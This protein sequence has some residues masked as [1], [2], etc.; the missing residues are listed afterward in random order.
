VSTAAAVRLAGAVHHAK[1]AALT[2]W[3]P[4]LVPLLTGM[5]R[6][7]GHCVQSY[8]LSY[9][10]VPGILVPAL[11]HL[12]D[13]AFVVV[14]GLTTVLLFAGLW[15]ALCRLSAP[16]NRALQAVVVLAIA[17]ESIG[18]AHALRA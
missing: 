5:L 17:V 4:V 6:D 10:L 18:Y 13:A 7:C 16:W 14:G 9:V 15:R 12:D 3:L 8:L 2:L 11:L 1:V